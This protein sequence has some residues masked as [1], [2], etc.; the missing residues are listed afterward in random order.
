MQP[1]VFRFPAAS[2]HRGE[3]KSAVK[4]SKCLS[5]CLRWRATHVC[6]LELS[7][8]LHLTVALGLGAARLLRPN[9]NFCWRKLSL[10]TL[11]ETT[12]LKNR[13]HGNAW[14]GKHILS[15]ARGITDR[16]LKMA[17]RLPEVPMRKEVE[18]Q[19]LEAFLEALGVRCDRLHGCRHLSLGKHPIHLGVDPSWD[20]SALVSTGDGCVATNWRTSQG[21]LLSQLAN[22]GE[23]KPVTTR[24]QARQ[25][26]SFCLSFF[27]FFIFFCLTA[28]FL[29]LLLLQC[30]CI[31]FSAKQIDFLQDDGLAAESC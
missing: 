18:N 10:W 15:H 29:R 16:Q 31:G 11:E 12:K 23:V 25:F 14:R 7:Q 28:R 17:A 6:S 2:G 4:P 22:V 13:K 30:W 5:T 26:C 20:V 24:L 27:L 3:V 1:D 19:T 9:F 21:L 8:V